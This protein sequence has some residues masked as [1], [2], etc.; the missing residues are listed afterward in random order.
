MRK[1]QSSF[2]EGSEL[3]NCDVKTFSIH[4]LWLLS[5]VGGVSG[6]HRKGVLTAHN[7]WSVEYETATSGTTQQYKGKMCE[8][9]EVEGCRSSVVSALVAKAG[10]PGFESPAT[11]KIFF[12]FF[13]CFFFPDPFR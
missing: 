3:D 5:G 10:G 1:F 9:L 11:T 8:F 13:L 6:R 12:T 2:Y 7:W 4:R